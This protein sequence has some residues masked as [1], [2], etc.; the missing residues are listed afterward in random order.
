MRWNEWMHDT[1][2]NRV[3]SL[4]YRMY[5]NLADEETVSLNEGENVIM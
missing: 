4:K 3:K 1:K 2:T 5:T